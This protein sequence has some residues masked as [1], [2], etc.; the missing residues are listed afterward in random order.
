[1]NVQ[2]IFK[3]H[4]EVM[5]GAYPQALPLDTI[6]WRDALWLVRD[7]QP[8]KTVGM[9]QPVRAIHPRLYRFDKARL[10]QGADYSLVCIVPKAVLDRRPSSED[11]KMFYIVEAPAVEYPMPTT[12]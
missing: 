3:T 11:A 10:E 7:W 2:Q 12:D 8:A 6:S 4:V 5:S 9:R 1:M